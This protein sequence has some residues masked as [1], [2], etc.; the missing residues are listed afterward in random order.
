M[1]Q[2]ILSNIKYSSVIT[3][4]YSKD[5]V[6]FLY[7]E[8]CL[9]LFNT[10]YGK[11]FGSGN[12][13]AYDFLLTHPIRGWNGAVDNQYLTVLMDFGLV[14]I[15][16][17]FSLI[18]YAFKKTISSENE[19]NQLCALCLLAMFISGFFYEMFSWIFVTLLFCLFFCILEK[20][21]GQKIFS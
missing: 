4:L 3:S 11:S 17:L 5:K 21:T 2:R 1:L 15:V 16:F 6:E 13:Y 10:G 18:Y 14:G 20:N 7:C 12:G 8:Y 9:L 19:I